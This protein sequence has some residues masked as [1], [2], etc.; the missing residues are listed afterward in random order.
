MV[1]TKYKKTIRLLLSRI[2]FI[3]K[4]MKIYEDNVAIFVEC[5]NGN[6]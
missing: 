6:K 3:V 5:E 1:T 2:S 4:Y